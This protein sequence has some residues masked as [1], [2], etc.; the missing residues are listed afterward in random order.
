MQKVLTTTEDFF[1]KQNTRNQYNTNEFNYNCGGYA[2]RTFSWW[3]PFR[4]NYSAYDFCNDKFYE[5]YNEKEVD[6]ALL[7]E[8]I[9]ILLKEFPFLQI[10]NK[11]NK[12]KRIIAFRIGTYYN[13][14][15]EEDYHLG[16]WDFHFKVKEKNSTIWRHKP[17]NSPIIETDCLNEPWDIDDAEDCFQ[18]TSNIVY[19]VD[20]REEN[21][22]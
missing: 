14:E 3:R 5:G 18:Y 21:N 19:F 11:P 1:N 17:G 2:L 9:T 4:G 13:L 10:T 7:T 15:C 20:E 6:D 12:D 16:D 8:C 22:A